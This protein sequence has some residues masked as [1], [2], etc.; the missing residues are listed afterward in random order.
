MNT[1]LKI[2]RTWKG[3]TTIE[4]APIYED[5]LINEIFPALK[6]KGVIGLEKVSI[7]TQNK[8]DEVE[9]FVIIQFESLDAV[10]TFAGENYKKA[11][12]PENA[13]KVLLKYDETV[14][15]YELRKE[16]ILK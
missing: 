7:S 6:K 14:E 3:W 16:L 15:Y 2:I 4:N 9:F 5:M 12:I 13:Q 11:Y 8:K 1:T 10:K